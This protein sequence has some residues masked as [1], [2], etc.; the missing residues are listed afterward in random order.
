MLPRG[1]CRGFTDRHD[2]FLWSISD[3]VG[4]LA[5]PQ[6][7]NSVRAYLGWNLDGRR[8]PGTGGSNLTTGTGP[9]NHLGG[10]SGTVFCAD[11]TKV[12]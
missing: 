9:S 5:L 4:Q 3:P 6:L 1:S 2:S 11:D 10:S 7:A 12:V 8:G